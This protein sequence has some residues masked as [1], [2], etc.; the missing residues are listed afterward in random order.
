MVCITSYYGP[1]GGVKPNPPTRKRGRFKPR[2]AA[3]PERTV[4]D[5]LPR[6]LTRHDGRYYGTTASML[7]SRTI[8]YAPACFCKMDN[9]LPARL[10]SVPPLRGVTITESWFQQ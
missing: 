4:A 7:A 2:A 3:P 8:T 5:G 9:V 6:R 10:T 1:T